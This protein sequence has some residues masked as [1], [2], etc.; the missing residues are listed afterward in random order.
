MF[1]GVSFQKVRF[2]KQRRAVRKHEIFEVCRFR[3]FGAV[4][5][6]RFQQKNREGRGLGVSWDA[7]L[8]VGGGAGPGQVPELGPN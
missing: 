6:P 4:E 1:R 3:E 2:Q 8:G 5:P 7:G